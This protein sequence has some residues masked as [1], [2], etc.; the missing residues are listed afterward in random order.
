MTAPTY[1]I[2][3]VSDF[4][5]VPADRRSE[6]FHELALSLALCEVTRGNTAT[7]DAFEWTDDGVIEGVIRSPGSYDD[8]IR[9]RVT[10]RDS[11]C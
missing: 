11:E 10:K 1:I 7:L 6:M 8:G 4:F 9:L 5:R 3:T 2:R